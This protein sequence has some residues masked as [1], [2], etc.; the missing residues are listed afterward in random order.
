MN[1]W[2]INECAEVIHKWVIEYNNKKFYCDNKIDTEW[3]CNLLNN[4][5]WYP[6]PSIIPPKLPYGNYKRYLVVYENGYVEEI[7]W[8]FDEWYADGS[9]S[10]CS[11]RVC[12][13]KEKPIFPNL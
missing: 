11:D 5:E 12:F 3:L 13:W 10:N 9:S 1:K 4:L 8:L 7:S 2:Q 6:Y